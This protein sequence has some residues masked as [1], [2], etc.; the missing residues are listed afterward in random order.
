MDVSQMLI[1][2]K[3]YLGVFAESDS[4]GQRSSLGFSI[5]NNLPSD[6]NGPYFHEYDSFDSVYIP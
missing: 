4:L 6:A 5:S 3:F 1:A 2:H